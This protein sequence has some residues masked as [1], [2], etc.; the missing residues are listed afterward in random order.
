M[1]IIFAFDPWRKS[2]LLVA[3]D[4]AGNWQQWYKDA[5]PLAEDRFKQYLEHRQ[6]AEE[7]R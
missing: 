6:A 3:G 7:Q 4:K 1:R 2:V 5:I